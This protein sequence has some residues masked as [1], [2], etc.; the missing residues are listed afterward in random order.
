MLIQNTMAGYETGALTMVKNT[1][2][3]TTATVQAT[4][5]GIVAAISTPLTAPRIVAGIRTIARR[6]DSPA[7]PAMITNAV[8]ATTRLC[9]L[10]TALAITPA[11]TAATTDWMASAIVGD[12]ARC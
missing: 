6:V 4:V 1:P 5:S 9:S 12:S 7:D 10:P 2:T 11:T 3:A 8:Q